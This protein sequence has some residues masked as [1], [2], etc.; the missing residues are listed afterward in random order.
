VALRA[1]AAATACIQRSHAASAT[2]AAAAAAA[3]AGIA[4]SGEAEGAHAAAPPLTVLK[5]GR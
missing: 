1:S 3:A 2:A 4:P 5:L